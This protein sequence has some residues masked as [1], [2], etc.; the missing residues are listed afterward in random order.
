MFSKLAQS[1]SA[2]IGFAL[3]TIPASLAAYATL[4]TTAEGLKYLGIWLILESINSFMLVGLNMLGISNQYFL[5]T[6]TKWLANKQRLAAIYRPMLSNWLLNVGFWLFVLLLIL[7]ADQL[8]LV[9]LGYFQ[10]AIAIAIAEIFSTITGAVLTVARI[11][12]HLVLA[13]G[14]SQIRPLIQ[15]AVIIFYEA[16]PST[17]LSAAIPIGACAAALVSIFVFKALEPDFNFV[18]PS[19][20]SY[21]KI[22]RYGTGF[23]GVTMTDS[24]YR[25]SVP[26]MIGAVAGESVVG[27][28]FILLKLPEYAISLASRFS[29]NLL[30][31][32]ARLDRAGQGRIY[33]QLF[34]ASCV[35]GALLSLFYALFGSHLINAIFSLNFN[36]GIFPFVSLLVMI[37]LVA[38]TIGTFR[39]SLHINFIFLFTVAF[40]YIS[41]FVAIFLV[42]PIFIDL[43]TLFLVVSCIE[44]LRLNADL[45]FCNYNYFSR[46]LNFINVIS[47]IF[48]LFFALKLL[49][50][51]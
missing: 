5:V 35:S 16:E 26:L 22:Q 3:A 49:K 11:K 39:N 20:R 45:C 21:K 32:I 12:Q 19:L 17:L 28:F 10:I 50:V 38:A 29:S 43:T 24:L 23:G 2:D 7:C 14:L 27:E 48:F 42:K 1:G 44:F 15:F 46:F 4:S 31:M 30:P 47:I 36:S 40:L 8:D 33:L 34:L 51:F 41:Y 18:W 13:N 37:R 25:S 9:E 6:K